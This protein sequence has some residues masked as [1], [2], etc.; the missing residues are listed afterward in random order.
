MAIVLIALLAF[1]FTWLLIASFQPSESRITRTLMINA[2]ADTLFAEVNDP[3]KFN[4]WSP[5]AE[6][7]PQA[8][9]T[10]AGPAEGV[11]ASMT[12]AGKKCGAGTSTIT[13]SQKPARVEF[14]LDFVKP[15]KATN[16]A[17]FT[18]VP[19]GSHTTQVEWTM[20]GKNNFLAKMFGVFI[21]CEKMVG[22]MFEKGLQNLKA[23][24]EGK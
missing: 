9:V 11:D 10:Y 15:M 4:S 3:R 18:F 13:A 24:T 16:T 6:A 22:K 17:S 21:N 12:W 2:P 20:H 19:A 8:V 14:R 7:D 23:K 5:F 1:I